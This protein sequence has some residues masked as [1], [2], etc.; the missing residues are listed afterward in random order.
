MI[1]LESILPLNKMAK[2]IIYI[3]VCEWPRNEI[4]VE[5][6]VYKKGILYFRLFFQVVECC[7]YFSQKTGLHEKHPETALVTLLTGQKSYGSGGITRDDAKSFSSLGVAQSA[8]EN[9]SLPFL[10][11]LFYIS[12]GNTQHSSSTSSEIVTEIIYLVCP[13][14]LLAL[15]MKFQKCDRIQFSSWTNCRLLLW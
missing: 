1:H 14:W 11:Q 13:V 9:G 2:Y 7:H 6:Y 15:V 3:A 4:L 10:I 8:G 12:A 5:Y